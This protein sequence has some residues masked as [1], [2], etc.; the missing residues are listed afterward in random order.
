MDILSVG[1]AAQEL[2]EQIGQDVRPRWITTL[3]YDRALRDDLCPIVAGRRLIPRS[4]LP[5]I[6]M[7][8][9]R[10]GWITEPVT[11]GAEA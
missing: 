5:M 11:E 7:A 10:R 3:F 6:V 8:M 4:Y 1:D 9:R 2:A